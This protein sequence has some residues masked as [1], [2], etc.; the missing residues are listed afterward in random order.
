MLIMPSVS[1]TNV[2]HK[3]Q[4]LLNSTNIV[5][6]E[7]EK[8]ISDVFSGVHSFAEVKFIHFAIMS[9]T[10]PIA[11]GM[12]NNIV[13]V[14]SQSKHSVSHC[15]EGLL[16]IVICTLYMVSAHTF[17]VI[18]WEKPIFVFTSMAFFYS[19]NASRVIISTVTKKKFSIF[20]DFHLT[21][22]IV[23]GIL[24]FPLNAMG[25]DMNE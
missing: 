23:I 22:P 3:I 11:C 10:F 24:A 21:L 7:D 5:P 14:L 13:T 9:G 8:T 1:E 15:L 25:L 16:P 6:T 4:Y 19:L 18:A 20:I 17:S 12:I 2:Q